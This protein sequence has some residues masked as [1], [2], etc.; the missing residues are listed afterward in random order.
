MQS[1]NNFVVFPNK[2]LKFNP[3]ILEILEIVANCDKD[4]QYRNHDT[5][6]IVNEPVG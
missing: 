6:I 3:F 5:L 2:F 1:Y 4:C